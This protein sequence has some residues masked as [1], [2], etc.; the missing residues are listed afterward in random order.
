MPTDEAKV[1]LLTGLTDGEISNTGITALLE[2]ND[3]T[4][5]LAAAD[6]LETVAGQLAT[7]TASSDDISIDGSKRAGVLMARA[8]R[9]RAAAAADAADHGFFFDVVAPAGYRP[10]LTPRDCR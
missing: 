5:K 3:G 2:M 6:A 8:S 4:V 7:V 1:R 9:L 10:E